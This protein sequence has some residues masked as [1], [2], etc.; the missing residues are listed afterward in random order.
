MTPEEYKKARKELL[1][2]FLNAKVQEEDNATHG[3]QRV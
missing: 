1:E 3:L 2:I